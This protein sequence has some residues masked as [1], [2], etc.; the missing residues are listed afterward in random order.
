MQRYTCGIRH[1]SGAAVLAQAVCCSAA[2]DCQAGVRLS[3]GWQEGTQ[4]ASC[5]HGS[6]HGGYA[7]WQ[8]KDMQPSQRGQIKLTFVGGPANTQPIIDH[9]FDL[10]PEPAAEES[11]H[12]AELHS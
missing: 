3:S 5:L 9:A 7:E 12:T 4:G 6:S 11:K 8:Q 2:R 1:S 10:Y